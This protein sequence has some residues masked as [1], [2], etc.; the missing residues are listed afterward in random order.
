MKQSSEIEA[1][2]ERLRRDF[3]QVTGSP[4]KHFYCPI[5]QVDEDAKL[6]LGH[7]INES[8]PN[9][10]RKT[11]LQR[12]DVDNFFG[13][14]IESDFC[15]VLNANKP[16]VEQVL[17][18][19]DLSRKIPVKLFHENKEIPFYIDNGKSSISHPTLTLQD[20]GT[21]IVK[22][23]L[24]V[25]SDELP[26]AGPIHFEMGRDFVPEATAAY[27]KAAHLTM[28]HLFGYDYC[29][30]ASGVELAR[31]LRTFYNDAKDLR[32][33][34]RRSYLQGHFA[35][36][37]GMIL[38]FYGFNPETVRGSIADRRFFFSMGASGDIFAFG[39]LVRANTHMAAV[40]LLP[41]KVER[42]DTYFEF[43]K[44]IEKHE[45]R[46]YLA[47]YVSASENEGAHWSVFDKEFVFD[48][49]STGPTI[50]S[51]AQ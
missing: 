3:E 26:D 46:Y 47:E 33:Q 18:D 39:V 5:L 16:T 25:S 34:N 21:A 14:V 4:F 12:A 20:G 37:A 22:L 8:I 36:Y 49:F 2:R 7:I 35:Q 15:A 11:V 32:A 28:F 1:E 44:H 50:N 31:I 23:K 40:F 13:A 17:L 43:V 45:F 9:T 29:E 30:S 10:S 48:P 51:D 38:P 42:L 27:I 19:P 41:D 24:K 6:C